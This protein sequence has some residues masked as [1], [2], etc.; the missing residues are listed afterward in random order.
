MNYLAHAYRHL[1]RPEPERR[2]F[3]AGLACPDW[4]SVSDRRS[5]LRE[6]H[7]RPHLED[8]DPAR[9]AFAAGVLRHLADDAWF[10][11]TRAF[12]EVT[13]TISRMYR[14]LIGP[15]D[16]ARTGFL[17]HITAEMLLDTTLIED[18]PTLPD[19]YYALI[20]ALA[21]EQIQAHARAMC[22]RP[23]AR[24]AEF[25]T[26]FG[27][28]QFLRDYTDTDRLT[29]RISQVCR[30][31]RLEPLPEGAGKMLAEALKTVRASRDALL[32]GEI[33]PRR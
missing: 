33:Q 2:W 20:D 16:H 29:F 27:R 12:Y 1:D 25:V 22:P 19:R 32:D 7:V 18:D 17:G 21:P 5:R 15:D 26:M 23:I 10:H 31:A 28:S 11:E 30:R 14:D 4:L 3:V 8:A 24:L 13:G 6:K 9:R